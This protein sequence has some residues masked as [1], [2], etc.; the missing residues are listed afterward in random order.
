MYWITLYPYR[1]QSGGSRRP[2][3]AHLIASF[4]H[5]RH[6]WEQKSTSSDREESRVVRCAK[7]LRK[8][9]MFERSAENV[10]LSSMESMESN[11]PKYPTL[12]KG[13]RE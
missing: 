5:I 8:E 1:G 12:V 9:G 3:W 7:E 10:Q 11:I 6:R 13:R 2:V 4:L